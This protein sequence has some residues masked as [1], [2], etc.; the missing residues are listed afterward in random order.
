[1]ETALK[2]LNTGQTTTK[3]A[4]QLFDELEAVKLDFMWGRWRGCGL[5]TH[6]P[7]DGLLESSNWYGKEFIDPETVNPLLFLDS[8]GKLFKVAPNPTAMKWLAHSPWLQNESLKPIITL[9][10]QLM[11]TETSQ[12]RLRMMEYRGKVSATMI[13]DYLPINDS[14][15]KIDENT[16][17][18][19]MDYKSFSQ[20]F[21]FILNR[22]R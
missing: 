2:R 12:A 3:E 10:T 15:R 13:Y 9:T 21:F 11:R 8:Q 4:L 20:P 1:M 14:F 5:H 19:M 18:G 6:H 17:L 22:D 7:M 16:L